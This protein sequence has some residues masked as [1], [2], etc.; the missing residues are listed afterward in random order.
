MNTFLI[1]CPAR[2]AWLGDD[3]H[4]FTSQFYEAAQFTSAD[5]AQAIAIREYDDM[6]ELIVV[7]IN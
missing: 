4:R 5:L 7:G 1:Y 2:N 6:N 3:E